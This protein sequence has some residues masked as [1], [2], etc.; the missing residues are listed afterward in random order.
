MWIETTAHLSFRQP[1]SFSVFVSFG[2][3]QVVH[4]QASQDFKQTNWKPNT[5]RK[6]PSDDVMNHIYTLMCTSLSIYTRV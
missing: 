2:A 3:P 5:F 4:W 1:L 6:L